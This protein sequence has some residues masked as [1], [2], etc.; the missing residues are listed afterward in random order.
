MKPARKGLK[1]FWLLMC[2]NR[3]ILSFDRKKFMYAMEHV[4]VESELSSLFRW[5]HTVD[6][7]KRRGEIFVVLQS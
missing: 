3:A 7:V 2:V 4:W 5:V 1:S 6:S